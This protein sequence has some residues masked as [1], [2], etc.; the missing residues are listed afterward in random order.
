MVN[1]TPGIRLIVPAEI[2]L[3]ETPTRRESSQTLGHFGALNRRPSNPSPALPSSVR[4]SYKGRNNS[5]CSWMY[6][7]KN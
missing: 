7:F 6:L 5:G 2:T 4:L 3:S 1:S